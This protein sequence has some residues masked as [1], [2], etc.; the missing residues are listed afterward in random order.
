MRIIRVKYRQIMMVV[1]WRYAKQEIV[2][3]VS[4]YL[5]IGKNLRSILSALSDD[6]R[7]RIRI[8]KNNVY[9]ALK[10]FFNSI[11]TI[12]NKGDTI[13]CYFLKN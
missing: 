3:V 11:L 2:N 10:K 7:L 12:L 9:K 4:F 6:E 1:N 8:E 5:L 13:K